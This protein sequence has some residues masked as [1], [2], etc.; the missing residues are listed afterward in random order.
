MRKHFASYYRPSAAEFAKL[1]ADAIVSL[2]ANVL[3]NFYRY[4]NETR[5]Q[6]SRI[7]EGLKSRLWLTHQAAKEF[8]S[9]RT[10]VIA[11]HQRGL[12]ETRKA[13]RAA[14]GQ[15][16][17]KVREIYRSS[18][19][20]E[21]KK[22]WGSVE[23]AMDSLTA[24]IEECES[25]AIKPTADLDGDPIWLLLTDLFDGRV[26]DP[27]PPADLQK[28]LEGG[29]TRYAKRI[30]PG[31][32]DSAKPGDDAYGDWIL[33]RQLLDHALAQTKPVLLVTDDRKDDWWL[34]VNDRTVGPRPELIE[35]MAREA[36]QAF[37]LYQPEQFLAVFDASGEAIKE[38]AAL[39]PIDEER[40]WI[41]APVQPDTLGPAFP[42]NLFEFNPPWKALDGTPGSNLVASLAVLNSLPHLS[43]SPS[44][45]AVLNS[46]QQLN[47]SQSLSALNLLL[48]ANSGA[49]PAAPTEDTDESNDEGGHPAENGQGDEDIG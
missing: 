23:E 49:N 8:Q 3:L 7:L 10:K 24:H 11:D 21:V 16:E 44:S 31:H 45:L 15:V 29:K 34:R 22:R 43:L 28:H 42:T 6:F 13:L 2:D 4:S 47:L 40:S 17:T 33:W 20:D 39:S 26:G 25:Q 5:Q 14:R 41:S 38:A 27:Y 9:D 1:K 19:S 12:A 46:L 18:P 32:A 36:G 35:E 37:Y 30:P 48:G